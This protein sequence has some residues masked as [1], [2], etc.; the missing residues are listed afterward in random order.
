MLLAATTFASCIIWLV[1]AISPG[2]THPKARLAW[3]IVASIVLVFCIIQTA[4]K[5]Q[6]IGALG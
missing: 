3:L 2:D 5:L 6:N 1:A 4:I